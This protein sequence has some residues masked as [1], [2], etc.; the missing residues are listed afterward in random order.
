M[1]SV[2]QMPMMPQPLWSLAR[3][4]NRLPSYRDPGKVN[5]NTVPDEVV[6]A[7]VMC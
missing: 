7:A 6:W 2:P 4:F 3:P 5:I 1:T